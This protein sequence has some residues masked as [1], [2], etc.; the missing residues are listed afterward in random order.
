MTEAEFDHGYWYATELK[1]FGVTLGIPGASKLRKDQLEAAIKRFLRTGRVA[2][3]GTLSSSPR[4][5]RD[6]ERSLRP[7]TRIVNYT[8][9]VAT[10]TF[11]LTHAGKLDPAFELRSGTRYPLNRWR[12]EQIAR[13]RR[14]TYGDLVKH[15]VALNRGPRKPLRREHGRY[16][17][18]V[19]DFAK[20]NPGVGWKRMLAAWQQLK[21]LDAPKTYASWAA[22]NRARRR[23]QAG[24]PKRSVRPK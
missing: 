24:R 2:S 15:F 23:T 6:S 7:T 1:A 17:N 16:N 18:F 13:G 4:G 9:D 11:L 20:A 3:R 10:K 5:P 12:E 19:A 14:L 22:H 21:E 8:N